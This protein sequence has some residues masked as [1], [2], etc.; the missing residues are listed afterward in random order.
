[1]TL[2]RESTTAIESVGL[3]IFVVLLM[4]WPKD[5]YFFR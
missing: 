3:P 1:M 4:W 2:R 5:E